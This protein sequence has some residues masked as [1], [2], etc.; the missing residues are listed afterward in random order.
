[1]IVGVNTVTGNIGSRSVQ[2]GQVS[3]DDY[4][5]YCLIQTVLR[6]QKDTRFV[7]FAPEEDAERYEGWP[8]ILIPRPRGP[9]AALR[10]GVPNLESAIQQANIDVLLSPIEGALSSCSVPQI[11]YALNLEPWLEK[12]NQPEPPQTKSIRKACSNAV[13]FIV[14][15]EYYRRAC[16]EHFQ[17]PLNKIF[18]VPPGVSP[19][20][21]EQQ[22]FSMFENPFILLCTDASTADSMDYFL[23][24][25]DGLKRELGYN[26]V[27]FG[28]GSSADP[29]DWGHDAI[30]IEHFPD[31]Q[32]AGLFQH[33]KLYVYPAVQ[34]GTGVRVIEGLKAGAIT[35]TPEN[36]SIHEHVGATPLFY[37]TSNKRALAQTIRR[38][39]DLT[40]DRREKHIELGQ[41]RVREFDW[42][43]SAW[44]LLQSLKRM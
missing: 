5:I 17:A 20:L 29:T 9:M 44:K 33:S 12:R 22:D 43:K 8:V 27:V 42:E 32:L 11:L 6:V 31:T 7:M 26:L 10:G 37:T 19:V 34:E 30:R 35:I 3:Y 21:G 25:W 39:L 2:R 36:K 15:S 28:P 24:V 41:K 4:Y 18:V 1:M 38:A 40:G 23:T 16:L 14:P 13:G